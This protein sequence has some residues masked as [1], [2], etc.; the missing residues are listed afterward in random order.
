MNLIDKHLTTVSLDAIDLAI[1][2]LQEALDLTPPGTP[3]RETRLSSLANAYLHR[4]QRTAATAD[5]KTAI[6]LCREGI[7][8]TPD[9][10]LLRAKQL[11][12]LG[13]AY[14]FRY[15]QSGVIHDIN[16][17]IRKYR[18][19]LDLEVSDSIT[20][21]NLTYSLGLGYQARYQ[22]TATLAD[23]NR[24]NELLEDACNSTPE[25]TELK[26]SRRKDLALGYQVKYLR[27]EQ[28][29]DINKAISLSRERIDHSSSKDP[30][31]ASFHADL[32]VAYGAKQLKGGG[33]KDLEKSIQLLQDAVNL[34]GPS[35]PLYVWM[36]EELGKAYKNRFWET[37]SIPDID[38][39][40]ENLQKA[41]GVST[42]AFQLAT[43]LQWLSRS[44]MDKFKETQ[45]INDIDQSIQFM[46]RSLDKTLPRDIPRGCRLYE[47]GSRYG[48]K[49]KVTQAVKDYTAATKYL[50]EV[51]HDVS[52]DLFN[53]IL[54]GK[55]AM[56]LFASHKDWQKGFEIA[57]ALIELVPLLI[58]RFLEP[59]DTQ[60]V[61]RDIAGIACDAAAMSL[62]AGKEPLVA[63][64][65][66]EAGRDIMATSIND[67]RGEIVSLKSQHPELAER[68]LAQRHSLDKPATDDN[69]PS[70]RYERGNQLSR[71]IDQIRQ[72][73]GFDDF[74]RVP[75]E[76]A[77]KR[78]AVEYPIVVINVSPYR[79]DAIIVSSSRICSM[80]LPDLTLAK[81]KEHSPHRDSISTPVVLSWLWEAAT[82]PILDFI[83]F[84]KLPGTDE[85]WPRV[86]WIPTGP[87]CSYPL[88]AAG[89]HGVGLSETVI[90]RVMS[91]YSSSVKA[92]IDGRRPTVTRM[93]TTRARSILISME[94]TPGAT[95]LPFAGREIE[96]LHSL[97]PTMSLD[98]INAKSKQDVI[99]KLQECSVFHFAGHGF[100]DR[101]DPS[102][103]HLVL[104]N[105][106]QSD[107]LE[108]GTLLSMNLR[109]NPPF[110]AYLS[111]CGTGQIK[112]DTFFD[113]SIH[114]ISAFR[115]AGFR[116]VV[117]TL[118]EVNDEYCID[119]ARITYEGIRD[120]GMTDDSVCK[121]LHKASR[122]LRKRCMSMA[123][124]G[125]GKQP[126]KDHVRST[127]HSVQYQGQRMPQ[128]DIL[129]CDENSSMQ[130]H[131]V[132]YVH[133]G[134]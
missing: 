60:Y 37:K 71:L 105:N 24:S 109:Q 19:G 42:N 34:S 9:G 21:I 114:L 32:G 54:A 13:D 91:S 43:Q 116:H 77:L 27:T 58:P 72:L 134:V 15:I 98:P 28:V 102:K 84:A 88:H 64:K 8:L 108:V 63:L 57:T 93:G 5:I 106:G 4:Y 110:L 12:T 123:N 113:E 20:W 129:L 104:Q 78:A 48:L 30:G 55:E 99:S 44:A 1:N 47:L 117:G 2:Y 107:S 86:C 82:K 46:E 115:L 133:F 97:H 112:N 131:W 101:Q 83:G 92:I 33:M 51:V 6:N 22:E 40:I 121:G 41:I 10:H 59:V 45:S 103:S 74:L 3:T 87:L 122:E 111:A 7:S 17:A 89:L 70:Q 130:L 73:P 125:S 90:D 68:F 124:S 25:G 39:A 29:V 26:N 18:E 11:K 96:M 75:G 16:Q 94:D 36:L 132:P 128:R 65:L 66:L 31:Y 67:L 118:W 50:Q 53:K 80:A 23:L 100:T 38:T 61:L 76:E 35:D 95:K 120:G 49:Y 79:C 56:D 14:R 126:Q 52:I 85:N 69:D 119:M 62:N 81:L 127:E